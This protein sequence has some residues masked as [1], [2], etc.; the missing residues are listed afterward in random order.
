MGTFATGVAV[1][2]V[3][4]STTVHGL[5]VSS[6]TSVSLRPAM[7][8]VCLDRAGRTTSLV[9][10]AGGFALSVLSEGQRPVAQWLSDPRRPDGAA[11]FAGLRHRPGPHT[12][13]PLL[14]DGLAWLECRTARIVESGDHDVVLAHVLGADSDPDRTGL[15][16][17]RG[18][19]ESAG[20]HLEAGD[21]CG[22]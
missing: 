3:R 18:R 20:G 15:I 7:L 16:H 13:A 6:L 21:G 22:V 1:L 17:F 9:R 14:T 2:T 10:A 19:Y 12:G 5:T 8:L 4:H 11:Q